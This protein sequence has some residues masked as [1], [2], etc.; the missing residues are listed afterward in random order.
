MKVNL[1]IATLW[2]EVHALKLR[3]NIDLVATVLNGT[4]VRARD[5]KGHAIVH[6]MKH[7]GSKECVQGHGKRFRNQLFFVSR[8]ER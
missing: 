4:I 1:K 3:K 8:Q 2:E 6:N 5:A 7:A